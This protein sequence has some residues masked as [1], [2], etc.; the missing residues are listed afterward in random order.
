VEILILHP[1][2]LGDIILSLPAIGLLRKRFP[3]ARLAIAGNLDHLA[4][5]GAGYAERTLSLSTLPLHHL[6]ASGEVPE[7][8]ALFWKSFDLIISWTGAG[9]PEFTRKL[10]QLNS[11]ARIVSWR[12]EPRD[13]R[14]VSQLFVDSLGHE[15]HMGANAAPASILVDP[16]ARIRA[17]EWLAGRGWNVRDRLI[18]LHPGAGSRMKR[19]P[20][21]RFIELARRLA[22]HEGTCLLII[23]GPADGGLATQMVAA[24]PGI[25]AIAVRS[26]PMNMLAALIGQCGVFVGNDSG[27][28]HL[29]AGLGIISVVL[30][31][32]T[33]PQHW[34][35]LGRHVVVLRDP[36]GC[37]AC[38]SAHG[39]HTCLS[40]ISV[41]E[42][43]KTMASA[44]L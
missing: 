39:E 6:H 41:E 11:G 32:P 1:G 15:L 20:L 40:K 3:S 27:I 24:L 38:D 8:E 16:D 9:D 21:S 4:A 5:V 44:G 17:A 23:E 30:F 28:A 35:P 10:R 18:A 13:P 33:L 2:G 37:E 43:L 25:R 7:A 31:G 29:A 34:A 14:H 36:R 42:V 12:P 26:M 22:L 19:W